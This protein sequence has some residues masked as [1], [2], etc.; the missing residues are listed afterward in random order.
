MKTKQTTHR[1]HLHC[2]TNNNQHH[3]GQPKSDNDGIVTDNDDNS[4]RANDGNMM[5]EDDIAKI[6]LL[7]NR[8]SI[9]D[10][11]DDD[12]DDEIFTIDELLKMGLQFLDIRAN[13][14]GGQK[15]KNPE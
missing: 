5:A 13:R 9:D 6:P 8:G 11:K 15:E 4:A 10:T 1:V 3:V 2:I 7:R 12:D 14:S